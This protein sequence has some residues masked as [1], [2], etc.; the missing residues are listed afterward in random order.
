MARSYRSALIPAP[1]ERVWPVVRD[2]DGLPRWHPA[3]A[4]SEIED[5]RAAGE[6][7]CVRHLSLPDGA[8]IRERL[9]L[10]DDPGRSLAYEILDGPFPIRSYRSVIRVAP[11]TATDETFVEWYADYDPETAGAEA[12]RKLDETFGGTVYEPGLRGLRQHFEQ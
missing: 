6:V 7:G 10:L 5:A 4:S 2:F 3:I 12:E 8:T 9:L 11:I 1:A